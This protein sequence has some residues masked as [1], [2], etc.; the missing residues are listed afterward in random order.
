MCSVVLSRKK[1]ARKGRINALY[2][3]KITTTKTKTYSILDDKK[4]GT[5]SNH[6]NNLYCIGA[7]YVYPDHYDHISVFIKRLFEVIIM[8]YI[9]LYLVFIYV[10]SLILLLMH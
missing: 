3:G 1:F 6:Y 4:I 8:S 9:F 7:L 10:T 5:V 2:Y